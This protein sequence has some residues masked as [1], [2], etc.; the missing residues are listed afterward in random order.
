MGL[1]NVDINSSYATYSW[2]QNK[3]QMLDAAEQNNLPPTTT[4]SSTHD[5]K[6]PC[7]I[8]DQNSTRMQCCFLHKQNHFTGYFDDLVQDG[9]VI[10]AGDVPFQYNEQ[11]E[12]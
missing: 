2:Y 8:Q 5:D 6:T 10:C 1:T 11:E 9:A 3:S 7:V 4:T 12:R